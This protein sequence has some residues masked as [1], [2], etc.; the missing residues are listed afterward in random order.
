MRRLSTYRQFEAQFVHPSDADYFWTGTIRG[1][2]R[3]S[4]DWDLDAKTVK[5][6]LAPTL[7]PKIL[8]D[9]GWPI[10]SDNKGDRHRATLRFKTPSRNAG[11]RKADMLI[12]LWHGDD[13]YGVKIITEI[14]GNRGNWES[15]DEFVADD[16][17]GLKR[18][19]SRAREWLEH[20]LGLGP[21]KT[22]M[23]GMLGDEMTFKADIPRSEVL[24]GLWDVIRGDI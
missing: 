8:Y 23:P 1:T 22:V 3:E 21:D 14:Q 9:P 13:Y 2:L 10:P 15:V 24:R 16:R 6:A 4:R 7:V 17:A 19:M 11:G 12:F 20:C 5:E 18:L